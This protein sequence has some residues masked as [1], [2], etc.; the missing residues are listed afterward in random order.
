MA[1]QSFVVKFDYVRGSLSHET[2]MMDL[3]LLAV[4]HPPRLSLNAKELLIITKR[5]TLLLC[6][7]RVLGFTYTP[8]VA[9]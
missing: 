7:S 4:R 3:L 9:V 8:L 2:M 1:F 6:E 5:H